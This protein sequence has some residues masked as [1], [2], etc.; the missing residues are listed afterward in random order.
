M[1][2]PKPPRGPPS[3]GNSTNREQNQDENYDGP[4]DWD[5]HI[6]Q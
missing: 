6:D 3:P 2:T 4:T 5:R 1:T